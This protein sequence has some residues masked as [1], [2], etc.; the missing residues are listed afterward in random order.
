MGRHQSVGRSIGASGRWA[1]RRSASQSVSR[2]GGVAC[3]NIDPQ[4][5][6]KTFGGVEGGGVGR[7]AAGVP[8]AGGGGGWHKASVSDCLPLA[9][10]TGLSPLHNLTLCGP[11]RVLVVSGGGGAKVGTPTYIPQSDPHVLIIFF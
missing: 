10:P 5:D 2:R 4:L 1:V 8:G 9:A 11:Q 3:L 7:S 6:A